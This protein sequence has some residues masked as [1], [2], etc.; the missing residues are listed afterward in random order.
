MK[1]ELR[2]SRV[3]GEFK[4]YF[5][6]NCQVAFKCTQQ[7]DALQATQIDR[8][9]ICTDCNKEVYQCNTVRQ[10]KI[11]LMTNACVAMT[12]DTFGDDDELVGVVI[13]NNN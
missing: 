9:R 8:I 3:L 13:K 10:L 4:S 7:W 2:K 6:R 12:S 5:I 1:N 11:A